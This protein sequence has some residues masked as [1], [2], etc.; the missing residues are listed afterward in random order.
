MLRYDLRFLFCFQL[1]SIMFNIC[2]VLARW[3]ILVKM[4]NARVGAVTEAEHII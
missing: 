2:V 3:A 1:R 4:T